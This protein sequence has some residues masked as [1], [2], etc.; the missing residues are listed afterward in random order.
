MIYRYITITSRNQTLA[1][2]FLFG[3]TIVPLCPGTKTHCK[4]FAK[5]DKKVLEAARHAV[6]KIVLYLMQALSITL[7]KGY[8][9]KLI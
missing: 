8:K 6:I 7:W 1:A 2:W 5:I 4:Y 9:L 3:A